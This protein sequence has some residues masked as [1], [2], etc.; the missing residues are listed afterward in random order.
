M[1]K[2]EWN[3]ELTE[4]SWRSGGARRRTDD[5][6]DEDEHAGD[7]LRRETSINISRTTGRGREMEKTSRTTE[8]SPGDQWRTGRG[9]GDGDSDEHG[10]RS[11]EENLTATRILDGFGP[12]SSSRRS[13]TMQAS[14]P[15]PRQ[16]WRRPGRRRFFSGDFSQC[17]LNFGLMKLA[18]ILSCERGKLCGGVERER[19]RGARV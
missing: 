11:R 16:A 1:R 4:R 6:G 19:W 17:Y 7:Q 9:R 18:L 10:R 13:R 15:T 14:I 8:G 3:G 5:A 2:G 12:D